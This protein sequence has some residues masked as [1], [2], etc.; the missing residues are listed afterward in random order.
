MSIARSSEAE[1]RYIP[2]KLKLRVRTGQLAQGRVQIKYYTNSTE[3]SVH[4]SQRSQ[5]TDQTPK[6]KARSLK[7]KPE[8][9]K[10]AQT[11]N[12]SPNL[13]TKAQSLKPKPE[14]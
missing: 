7:P 3:E 11:L 10:T 14:A 2:S 12:Q 8:P 6:T 1:A 5:Y 13:K 4:G 9:Q